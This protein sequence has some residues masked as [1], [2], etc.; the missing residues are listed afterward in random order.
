MII[1]HIIEN[2]RH[3]RTRL[4]HDSNVEDILRF[5]RSAAT[6]SEIIMCDENNYPLE[7]TE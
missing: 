4:F 5:T 2:D 6:G 3:Q 7:D 1:I